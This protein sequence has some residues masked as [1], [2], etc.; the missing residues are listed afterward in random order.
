MRSSSENAMSAKPSEAAMIARPGGTTH[1]F[2]AGL[3]K[4]PR[5][6][7]QYRIDPQLFCNGSPSPRKLR[8]AS[9]RIAPAVAWTN[10][11]VAS[12]AVRGS[13]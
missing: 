6:C 9:N 11:P 3:K 13:T 12:R 5:T 7:A 2:Q 10:S 4:A 8:A 1:H